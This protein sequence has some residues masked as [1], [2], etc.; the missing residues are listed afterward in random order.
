MIRLLKCEYLKT[1][2]CF[3]FPTAFAITAIC[4]CWCLYGDVDDEIIK[5]GWRMFLYQ[6]PLVNAI[7]LPLLSM[8]IASRLC[9][10]EHKGKMQ[11]LLCCMEKRGKLFDAKLLYGLGIITVCVVLMWAVTVIFGVVNRFLGP[12]PIKLYLLYFIFTLIPTVVIYIFQHTLSMLFKNQAIAFF[13][14]IIG[15]FIGIFSMFLP[16]LPF[17]RRMVLWGYYGVLQFVGLFG[18]TKESRYENA[19]FDLMP[20]DWTFFCVLI[21]AGILLYLIGRY[22][23]C[24]KEV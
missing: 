1:R 8:V 22:L 18:W 16:S 9:N 19:Y 23:F 6:F 17:L 20:I 21:C 13:T 11:K 10:L 2:H 15:E 4:L 12:F 5:Y 3:I 7:F 24:K 14:G